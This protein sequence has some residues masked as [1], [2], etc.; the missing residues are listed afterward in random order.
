[1]LLSYKNHT[2]TLTEQKKTKPRETLDI[3]QNKQMRI[4]H[5]S[6]A[7]SLIKEGK[8][9]S[10]VTS[11]ETTNSVFNTFDENKRFSFTIPGHWNSKSAQKTIDELKNY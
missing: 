4:F 6:P 8:W 1:M 2:D 5:F 7:I 3:K 10:A 9:L 11:F